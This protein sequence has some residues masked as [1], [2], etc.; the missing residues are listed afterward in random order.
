MA[1]PGNSSA[2]FGRGRRQCEAGHHCQEEE[3]FLRRQQRY[4]DVL[5]PSGS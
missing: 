1:G 3:A 2:A 4:G 5:L